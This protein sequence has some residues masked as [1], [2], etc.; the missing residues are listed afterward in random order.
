M[1]AALLRGAVLNCTGTAEGRAC[2]GPHQLRP[3]IYWLAL[4]HSRQEELGLAS[5]FE[6]CAGAVTD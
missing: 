3:R 2:V 6:I 4:L 1:S 5:H